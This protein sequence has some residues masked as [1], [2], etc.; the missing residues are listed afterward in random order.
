MPS[1]LIRA[2]LDFAK[3]CKN[4]VDPFFGSQNKLFDMF[5]SNLII[6]LTILVKHISLKHS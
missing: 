3:E 5:D 1:N 6:L 4:N 2:L